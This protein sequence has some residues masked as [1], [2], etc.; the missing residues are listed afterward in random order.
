M[1]KRLLGLL[2]LSYLFTFNLAIA[3]IENAC[4]TIQASSESG[5]VG[6]T[7]AIDISVKGFENLV[8]IQYTMGWETADLAYIGASDFNLTGLQASNFGPVQ[9]GTAGYLN[10]S[11][12]DNQ[13]SGITMPDGSVIYRVYFEVLNSGV[14]P[15]IFLDSPT[16]AEFV[17]QSSAILT[18]YSLIGGQIASNGSNPMI[19]QDAC[20]IDTDC[21][22][23][24]A[25]VVTPAVSGGNAP[26]AYSWSGP[27][28]FSS[29]SANLSGITTNGLYT[30]SVTDN[31]GQ[32]IESSFMVT[33]GGGI[34]L[35]SFI[36]P[37][38]CGSAN[39]G[40]IAVSAQGPG[41]YTY[42]WS[43][44]ATTASIS[45]L[46][47][48][49]YNLT[50]TNTDEDCELVESFVIPEE[51]DITLN[52]QTYP[53]SCTGI[54]DG[55][56]D[57][58][59]TSSSPSASFTFSWS[60]GA[61]TEDIQ[62]LTIGLYSVTIT[63]NN[64]CTLE[65]TY[66]VNG[67]SDLVLTA[68]RVNESC[69]GGNGS[70]NLHV[71]D[72]NQTYTYLWSN[73]ATTED[74]SDLETGTYTVTVT[75]QSGCSNTKT[76][77]ITNN[78]LLYGL[79]YN[80][81]SPTN[82][83]ITTIIWAGGS[84]PY[85]YAWSTGDTVITNSMIEPAV[86]SVTQN[87][88]YSLTITDASGDCST[89]AEGIEVDCLNSSGDVN[90]YFN[91]EQ[92]T[93]QIDDQYCVQIMV[94]GFEDI[95]SFQFSLNWNPL[96]LAFNGIGEFNVPG[97]DASNFGITPE[98]TNQG[99]LTVSWNDNGGLG[100]IVTLPDG[101][102]IF[103]AC[104]TVLSTANTNNYLQITNVPTEIEFVDGND[105]VLAVNTENTD[106]H[107]TDATSNGEVEIIG[108]Q[109][110]ANQGDIVCIPVQVNNF[111]GL[112]AMQFS[113]NW[114]P[115]QLDFFGVQTFNLPY[116]T[117][118]NFGL[119]DETDDG[120]LRFSWYDQA[121]QGI[122]RPDGTVIFEICFQVTGNAEVAYVDFTN[123]PI[124]MEVTSISNNT[125][126]LNPT[127][128]VI[129]ISGIPV[130]PGDTDLSEIV[131]HFDLLNI[132]LAFGESGAARPN[133][134]LLWQEQLA[135]PWTYAT[136]NSTI[137]AVHC[138][139]DGNGSIDQ[140][141]VLALAQ[142]WGET[143]NFWNEDDENRLVPL[144]EALTLNEA[145]I[146]VE[147]QTV[148]AG[149]EATFNILFGDESTLAEDVYG[150]AF[151]VVYDPEAVVFGSVNASFANSWLGNVDGELI[152]IFK[153][154]PEDNRID[155]AISRI[156]QQSLN[157]QGAI[158]QMN[159]TIEDVILRDEV[160]QMTFQI[161]NVR[162]INDQEEIIPSIQPETISEI[163]TTTG[164]T[165]PD[166]SWKLDIY[167][168]PTT[169]FLHLKWDDLTIEAI[170]ILS[171]DGKVEKRW[172]ESLQNLPTSTLAAGT[173]ILQVY[174]TEGVVHKRFVKM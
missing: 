58:T 78:G 76:I 147:P 145:T 95:E 171:L 18:N 102:S 139:T 104:F 48:G 123:S 24:G 33:Q 31:N 32:T 53:A 54:A 41:T 99:Q 117:I 38:V 151:T 44:G 47:A 6:D 166:L 114:N 132:G 26:F 125:I 146:M 75:N 169:N 61:T 101:S 163:N 150:L 116:L 46:A 14:S 155:I 15:I 136:P 55:S 148:N 50:V 73:G 90:L 34:Q 39:T 97:L 1:K 57:L 56:I 130:W 3:Q 49:I 88:I 74:L 160:Y 43:N 86:I 112:T 21:F 82:I 109:T 77:E 106:M 45:N 164:I 4:F 64:S 167:P 60:N 25:E 137:N 52:A 79:N 71:P 103:E 144:P 66:L 23:S 142:N 138:D 113:M 115:D 172:K 87:G 69:P 29:T 63:D 110:T 62:D 27:N 158:A 126:A 153:D 156:N 141:D 17:V 83:Q 16:P 96:A 168:I 107:V 89:V 128:G 173:Y 174:T 42:D 119:T 22:N 12:I 67:N 134:S 100:N 118:N 81:I 36:S 59:A 121:V 157:G 131:D 65:R 161:E 154:H 85:T 108:G 40:Q 162:I 159:L 111:N 35:N 140:D 2:F 72:P 122:T 124:V 94:D 7:I 91:Q 92:D 28:G 13:L 84:A 127:S 70:I 105:I 19:I 152:T 80:C 11:W 120:I 133:A 165:T 98:L 37:D 20:V 68:T 9:P 135:A 170:E 10:L 5:Q 129:S 93:L 143:T 51:A 8:G 149:Q 30:L